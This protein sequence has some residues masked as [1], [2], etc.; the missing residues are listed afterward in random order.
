MTL[1]KKTTQNRP[2]LLIKSF[3]L[4]K[5]LALTLIK[6]KRAKSRRRRI[7]FLL[8]IFQNLGF[9]PCKRSFRRKSA[10][11]TIPSKRKICLQEWPNSSNKLKGKMRLLNWLKRNIGVK[12]VVES[13]RPSES[14][15]SKKQVLKLNLLRKEERASASNPST[16]LQ[17]RLGAW[18][19][20]Q[21]KS[22]RFHPKRQKLSWQTKSSPDLEG[23]ARQVPASCLAIWQIQTNLKPKRRER[24]C[25]VS[26]RVIRHL[27]K[28]RYPLIIRGSRQ[29]SRNNRWWN[30]WNSFLQSEKTKKKL[31]NLAS[32]LLQM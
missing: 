8:L 23:W 3:L 19:P 10:C 21:Q 4:P 30:T 28:R 22:S 9:W 12:L 2:K 14:R 25:L 20:L 1:L 32:Q 15:S 26:S 5:K 24:I 17:V 11:K 13:D 18:W 7:Q 27:T 29:A 16:N 31:A 6:I